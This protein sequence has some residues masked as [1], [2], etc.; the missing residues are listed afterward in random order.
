MTK[1]HLF[2]DAEWQTLQFLPINI[3]S[4]VAI[5]DDDIDDKEVLALGQLL[6]DPT[7]T[8]D[9]FVAELLTSVQADFDALWTAYP[10]SPL[11]SSK[12]LEEAARVLDT[13][14]S[15]AEAESFKKRMLDLG[16][17]VARASGGAGPQDMASVDD[18]EYSTVMFIS[19]KLGVK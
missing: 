19:R 13:R 5:S 16:I 8:S 10:D 1:R 7:W 3:W 12:G 6:A 9:P 14:L 15:P 11:A 4:I 18:E 17:W 2:S